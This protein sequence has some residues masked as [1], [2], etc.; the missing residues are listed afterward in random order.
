MGFFSVL[1]RS[2][3]KKGAKGRA[4]DAAFKSGRNIFFF[5]SGS[6]L[7]TVSL[8]PESIKNSQLPFRFTLATQVIIL[9]SDRTSRT[10]V[11]AVVRYAV[12]PFPA[13]RIP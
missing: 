8:V 2:G 3:G 6:R 7:S 9:C 10:P 12:S 1:T 4:D 5:R 13:T 11:C